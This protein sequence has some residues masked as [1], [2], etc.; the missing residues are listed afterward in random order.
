MR[1]SLIRVFRHR[2]A[3]L[4]AIA[5]ATAVIV[6]P[7]NAAPAREARPAA[8]VSQ[9]PN[10]VLMMVDDW[11]WLDVGIRGSRINTPNID[12]LAARSL[13]FSRAY[14]ASP[15]C[16]PSRAALITGRYPS[17]V[18]FT[19]HIETE[20]ALARRNMEDI[21]E[22]H[23]IDTDPAGAASRNWL[24]LSEITIAERLKALGYATG[25]VGKWHLGPKPFYPVHQG[26]DEQYGVSDAGQPRNY[27]RPYFRDQSI[28]ADAFDGEYLDDRTTRD[29][30]AYIDRS[31]KSDPP[32]FLNLWWYGVHT[33]LIGKPELI[34][35][36]E[37]MGMDREKAITA[38]MV[39]AIDHSVGEVLAAIE[40]SG[41]KENTIIILTSDQGGYLANAPLKGRKND[42]LALYEGGARV[43]FFMIW[44]RLITAGRETDQ[45][46]SLIDVAP[47]LLEAA[48][49]RLDARLDGVSLLP[50][51]GGKS[52][53]RKSVVMYRHYED[54][55]AA[56]VEN[57]WKFIASWAGNH[58]LYDL[59][60]DIGE[61]RDL[62][63]KYPGR[64]AKFAKRLSD[65]RARNV[66][67]QELNQKRFSDNALGETAK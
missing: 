64:V 53:G 56:I 43:P 57:R 38:A 58:E 11:A 14:A 24:P 35:K 40:R 23:W 46:V 18:G 27:F 26:F 6:H 7:A 21:E 30:V 20:A 31:S 10:I 33:P 32:Y 59:D 9:R 22:F 12:R 8:Q 47:T 29:A 45:L 1:R 15:T 51:I 42:G 16:S 37:A 49:G 61:D 48:G 62:A 63:K 54:R 25:F 39:E 3:R 60:A 13:N 52:T 28:Y 34:S 50:S 19:R 5:C 17:K 41:E 2:V 65:W 66:D 55:Y 44:P 4:L 36:Y 67:L